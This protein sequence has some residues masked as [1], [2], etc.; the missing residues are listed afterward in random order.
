M[1]RIFTNTKGEVFRGAIRFKFYADNKQLLGEEK[2]N[3]WQIAGLNPPKDRGKRG[4]RKGKR[5]GG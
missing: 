5:F 2:L 1:S 3:F 4:D